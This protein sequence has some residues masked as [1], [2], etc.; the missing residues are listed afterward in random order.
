MRTHKLTK[1][2]EGQILIRVS[3]E[4]FNSAKE[5]WHTQPYFAKMLY[6]MGCEIGS[7]FNKFGSHEFGL[8]DLTEC[9][10]DVCSNELN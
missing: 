1:W 5:L 6:H 10:C 4:L 7:E 2:D 9:K 3:D 8:R